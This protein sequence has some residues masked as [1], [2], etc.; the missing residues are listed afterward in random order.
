[1][2]TR[3]KEWYRALVHTFVE[4][5]SEMMW[6]VSLVDRASSYPIDFDA[7]R[8]EVLADEYQVG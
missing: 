5:S 6:L 7:P 8:A 1:M 4:G 2:S 3:V